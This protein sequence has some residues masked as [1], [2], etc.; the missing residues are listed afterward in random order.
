MILN[1]TYYLLIQISAFG[2]GCTA[3]FV[4]ERDF[5]NIKV[6][7]FA[8]EANVFECFYFIRRLSCWKLPDIRNIFF[9]ARAQRVF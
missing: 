7:G 9:N 8:D 6:A 4:T 2:I 3:T 5:L 1:F